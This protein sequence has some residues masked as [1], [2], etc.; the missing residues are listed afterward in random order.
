MSAGQY[1]EGRKSTS[2]SSSQLHTPSV[3]LDVVTTRWRSTAARSATGWSKYTR[4]GMPTPTV[5]PSSGPIEG[6][7]S[8]VGSTVLKD[9]D[10]V[11][12]ASDGP[13]AVAVTV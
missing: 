8:V 10:A 11:V 9:V 2:E 5:V 13:A 7:E 12:P 3:G 4:V 6:V 1:V